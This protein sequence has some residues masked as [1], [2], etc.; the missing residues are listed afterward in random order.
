LRLG[1]Y[2]FYLLVIS[3]TTD[4]VEVGDSVS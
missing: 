2:C 3:T 1:V 4:C